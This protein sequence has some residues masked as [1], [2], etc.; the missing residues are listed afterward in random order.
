[1]TRSSP[2]RLAAPRKK[3]VAAGHPL[4][5]LL[6]RAGTPAPPADLDALSVELLALYAKARERFEV[7]A[8]HEA[9]RLIDRARATAPQNRHLLQLKAAIC[10]AMHRL[11]E[12][13][14]IWQKLL[15][16]WP[17]DHQLLCNLGLYALRQKRHDQALDLLSRAVALNPRHANSQLNLGVLH[18]A[19]H[20]HALAM[21]CFDAA[22]REEPRSAEIHFSIGCC[23]QAQ[24]RLPESHAAYERAL[25]FDSGHF[26][27]RSNLV[28][29]QHYLADFDPA[30]NRQQ[31]ERMGALLARNA[32][33]VSPPVSPPAGAAEALDPE[34][35][36]LRVG[37][38]SP[39]LSTHPVGYFLQAMLAALP[40]GEVVLHAYANSHTY[41]A[42]S[43]R[44]RP[45]FAVWRPVADLSAA[46]LMQA[47]AEDGIDILIDL[48]GHTKG[49]SLACFARRLAPVQ[50]GWLGYFSTTGLASIDFV[51]ADPISVPPQEERFFT[52]K[53]LRLPHTRYCFTPLHASLAERRL[54]S[55]RQACVTF[56]CYQALAKIN[57]RVLRAWARVMAAAPTA[58]LRIRSAQLDIPEVVAALR[59]RMDTVGLPLERVE[60]L[61]PLPYDA[62]LQSHADIDVLLDTFPYPGGT[63][64]AEALW[65]GVPTLALALP[66]M[67]GRQGEA[68]LKNG[69]LGHWVCLD[70]DD[71]VAKASA[72]GRGEPPWLDEAARLRAEAPAHVHNSPLYDAVG[73]ARDW[74]EALRRAWRETVQT[75]PS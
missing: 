59:R 55:A 36:P 6:Q 52:E 63:T 2:Y 67:L 60:T 37:L 71:Y 53:I 24:Q 45:A 54:S 51:L 38:V 30:A 1:M 47:I 61:A 16:R 34:R 48:A 13:E 75:G 44:L 40:A 15:E 17:D 5:R 18:A 35:K 4:F 42:M 19:H 14:A 66:G 7:N 49:N 65:L 29:T 39:D 27:A 62:Y 10:T 31:A 57:D 74:V 25:V 20:R 11:D 73:F 46:Q 72:I 8:L 70:E 33:P 22:L 26:G 41:D 28:F 21:A 43:A 3:P 23:L 12:A 58:R 32:P 69:G 64:T 50:M 68:I 56:G 9:D